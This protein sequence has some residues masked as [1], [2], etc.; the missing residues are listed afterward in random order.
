VK[1]YQSH[2]NENTRKS[3]NPV[4]RPRVKFE[5]ATNFNCLIPLSIHE[6]IRFMAISNG[7]TIPELIISFVN[8]EI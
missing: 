2:I 3:K 1:N 4:G 5:T 8:K 6:K 7:I